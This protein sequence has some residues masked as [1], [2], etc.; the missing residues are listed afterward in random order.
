MSKK[1]FLKGA[2]IL[3]IAGLIV[4]VMGAIFRIP[5]GNI[6]G[7]EGMGYYQT[8][9]PIYI[10]LLVFSTNGAPA[11][12]SKMVSERIAVG[13]A[14]E[15]HRVFQLSFL[16]ML[17]LGVISSAV[18]YF[19]AKPIV[20]LL[21][22]E[23]SYY[24]MAAIA[25]AL[26]FVPVMSVFRGYFQGM[27]EMGPTAVSQ[28]VEQAV[29]VSVGLILA[30]VLVSSGV[31]YAAGGACLGTSIGPI[32]GTLILC[33]I[34]LRKSSG[35][36]QAISGEADTEREPAADI[37][38]TLAYLAVPITIGVSILPI[39]NV[40]DVAIIMNRLQATGFAKEAAVS[41]YGQL[42]GMAGPIINIPQALALSIALSLVPAIAAAKSTRDKKFMDEN[43]S[44]GFR[45]AMMIGVP[46]AFGLVTL[47][48]PIMRLLYPAEVASAVNAAPSLAILAVGIIF[49]AVAQTMAGILQGLDKAGAAV[50][51]LAAALVVKSVLTYILTGIPSLNINGAAIGSSVAYA[52]VGIL[53]LLAVKKQT[54]T[55]FDLGLTIGRP[56]LSGAVMA[57]CV[58]AAYRGLSFVV[59]NTLATAAAICVGGAVYCAMLIWS[60]AI[61][62]NEIKALPKGELLYRLFRKVHLIKG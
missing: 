50:Y 6:I 41:L 28:L 53:N 42:S 27:Q 52:V 12:I 20:A 2:A 57:G 45:T 26:L 7:D 11:A 17:V 10:F 32:A 36:R 43:I 5:L 21:G 13:K 35:I 25:P 58:W 15:A 40:A 8:A 62:P 1:T 46:C 9:Y 18:V 39:M 4:Q 44:L 55:K 33:A 23:K 29:R 49:L 24:A 22:S 31:E 47:S 34:Y 38:K 19:G 56:L 16:L 54:K 30:V 59:G 48:E 61:A 37:L 3:G 60:K 51:S 14:K